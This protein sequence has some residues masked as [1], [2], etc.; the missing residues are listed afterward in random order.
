ML[1]HTECIYVW[2]AALG[3]RSSPARSKSL[4]LARS[5]LTRSELQQ[6]L[7]INLLLVACAAIVLRTGPYMDAHLD[8]METFAVLSNIIITICGATFYLDIFTESQTSLIGYAAVGVL[9]FSGIVLGI[10]VLYDAVPKVRTLM[11]F[12]KQT[13]NL[14]RLELRRNAL[15][16]KWGAKEKRGWC[17]SKPE[18]AVAKTGSEV[19]VALRKARKRSGWVK[20]LAVRCFVLSPRKRIMLRAARE[21][22][23]GFDDFKKGIESNA[24]YAQFRRFVLSLRHDSG[25]FTCDPQV[26]SPS[27]ECPQ[28]LPTGTLSL[29]T[30]I[31]VVANA[32]LVL[33][34]AKD[35]GIA[36]AERRL[37]RMVDGGLVDALLT[38]ELLGLPPTGNALEAMETAEDIRRAHASLKQHVKWRQDEA[39]GYKGEHR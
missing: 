24:G 31:E 39:E 9:V 27:M 37:E 28:G 15:M 4:L 25:E 29:T 5:A 33:L 8:V 20:L 26:A 13:K 21:I 10:I 23:Y 38:A 35:R 18:A 30:D 12:S 6:I 17:R 16:S 19:H 36:A 2:F 32:M 3:E 22:F 1:S 7:L 11:R 34:G 14:R